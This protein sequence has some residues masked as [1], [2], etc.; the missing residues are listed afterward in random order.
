MSAAL[1]ELY[2]PATVSDLQSRLLK[3]L[4]RLVPGEMFSFNVGGGSFVAIH[5]PDP[6][7]PKMFPRLVANL[8]DHP[9]APESWD[10]KG[11]NRDIA[12]GHVEDTQAH[13]VSDRMSNR[14]WRKTGLY[15]EYFRELGVNYQMG[16]WAA[17]QKL[18]AI[19]A[20]RT[21]RDF[22]ETDRA[23]FSALGCHFSQ[24]IRQAGAFE[25]AQAQLR[26]LRRALD[27]VAL[28]E[29]E[30]SGK[31]VFVTR[32]AAAWIAEFFPNAPAR[33][34]PDE[35]LNWVRRVQRFEIAPAPVIERGDARLSIAC[36]PSAEIEGNITILLS[37]KETLASAQPL[38]ALGLTPREA[39]V[40][41]WLTRGKTRGEIG[42]ILSITLATVNKH[43][44]HIY[45]K[46]GVE[47]ATAAV[48]IATGIVGGRS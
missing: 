33:Y 35:L 20:N 13:K 15:N 19:T 39:E 41:Y 34:L 18:I 42:K 40:L 6:V 22:N 48:S 28:L 31:I 25:E 38:E 29:V 26:S 27:S 5:Y 32:M 9:F 16:V 36:Q 21:H 8:K 37:R 7:N 17:P 1:Q 46:L 44:E 23:V 12:A 14:A 4:S 24:A 2:A 3:V 10:F 47:T 45:T 11:R 30:T 43:H